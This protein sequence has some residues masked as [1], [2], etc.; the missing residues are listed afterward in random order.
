MFILV[1][2]FLILI[3][4]YYIPFLGVCL[5]I[6]RKFYYKNQKK[7]DNYLLLVIGLIIFII[8]KINIYIPYL[9]DFIKTDIFFKYSK[10]LITLSIIFII[11]LF[12]N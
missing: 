8:N 11:D 9:S 7:F 6:F 10:R 3:T 2:M 1:N 5:L 4:L 12:G